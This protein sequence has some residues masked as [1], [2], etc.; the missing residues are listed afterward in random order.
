LS[1]VSEG[2]LP[3]ALLDLMIE[4]YPDAGVVV[5]FLGTPMAYRRP[6]IPLVAFPAPNDEGAEV[7]LRTGGV[8]ALVAAAPGR[9]FGRLAPVKDRRTFFQ[10]HYDVRISPVWAD[11]PEVTP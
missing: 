5:S 8:A 11:F 10:E 7:L 2:D 1:Q 9:P 3:T 6:R 4:R